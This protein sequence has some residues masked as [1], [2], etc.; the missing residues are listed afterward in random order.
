M[1]PVESPS[2]AK[3]EPKKLLKPA[4]PVLV[5]MASVLARAFTVPDVVQLESRGLASLPKFPL[6][7]CSPMGRASAFWAN[8]RKNRLSR[9]DFANSSNR[10]LITA[11][12]MGTCSLDQYFLRV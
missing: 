8:S 9:N 10:A 4:F 6:M 2:T 12:D 7:I 3:D 11:P 5:L 1:F